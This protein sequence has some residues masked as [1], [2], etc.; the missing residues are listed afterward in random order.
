MQF[1]MTSGNLVQ[2]AKRPEGILAVW[3]FTGLAWCAGRALDPLP[4]RFDSL[5]LH[6][7]RA[8]PSTSATILSRN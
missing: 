6:P 4:A 3:P 8:H 5:Q 2:K 1:C 7:L